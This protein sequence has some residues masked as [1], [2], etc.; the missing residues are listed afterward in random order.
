MEVYRTC[1]NRTAPLPKGTRMDPIEQLSHIGPA[2][3][4]LAD[5]IE[6]HQL[7]GATPCE[8]FTVNDILDHMITL[9]GAFSYWFRGEEALAVTPPSRDGQVPAAAFRLTLE[10]LLDAVRSPGA[11]ERTITAPMGTMPG[12][13]FARLVA[14]DGLVHGWDLATATGQAYDVPADVVAAVD[15]FARAALSAEMR[16]GDTFKAETN[17]SAGAS[18]LERLVAFSGR[19]V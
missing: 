6:P 14:F 9:G 18:R 16:D 2:L 1:G 15:E 12:E 5:R 17:P 10:N 3:I 4:G 8:R 13:T 11:L 19:T 7:T